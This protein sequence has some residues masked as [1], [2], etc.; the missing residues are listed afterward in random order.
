M[1]LSWQMRRELVQY[2]A[3]VYLI[4]LFIFWL[5]RAKLPQKP[6]HIDAYDDFK[7]QFAAA[8]GQKILL[9]PGTTSILDTEQ[10][11]IMSHC[12]RFLENHGSDLAQRE[13]TLLVS[14][15]F[16]YGYLQD[17]L[18][19]RNI[20]ANLDFLAFDTISFLYAAAGAAE[21]QK[22]SVTFLSG[23]FGMENLVLGETVSRHGSIHNACADF[24]SLPDAVVVANGTIIGEELY[25]L[26]ASESPTTTDKIFLAVNEAL[27]LIT[28]A[29]ILIGSIYL[30]LSGQ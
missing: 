18:Q 29:T 22:P 3:A 30:S 1:E 27:K 17:F 25:A 9:I 21:R 11:I 7:E 5:I 13:L 6:R 23:A 14:C 2:V 28:I 16:K 4:L 24:S 15:P 19:D 8:D 20:K 10:T 26:P 12:L